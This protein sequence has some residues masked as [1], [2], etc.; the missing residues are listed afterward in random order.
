VQEGRSKKLG[1]R[2]VDPLLVMTGR[3]YVETSFD[4]LLRRIHEAIGWDEEVIAMSIIGGEKK[5][6]RTKRK[7]RENA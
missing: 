1:Q 4:D 6:I 5:I 3:E 7:H 2:Y